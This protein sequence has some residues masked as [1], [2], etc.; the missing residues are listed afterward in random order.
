MSIRGNR[1]FYVNS[2]KRVSG[3]PSNFQYKLDIPT[4]ERF[5]TCCVL[6]LTIPKSFY[7]VRAGQNDFTVVMDGI[8]TV[9]TVPPGNYTSLN[10]IPMLTGLLNGLGQG[11]FTMSL[12]TIS[13]KYTYTYTGP[14][15]DVQFRL[16]APSMLGHQLGFPE[17]SNSTFV[18]GTLTSANVLDFIGTSTAF[19]HSDMVEDTSSILQEVY[20]DNK[21]PFSNMIYNCQFPA[22]YSKKMTNRSSTVFNFSLCD[23]HGMEI[24]LNG[25]ELLFTLL[26]YKKEDLTKLFKTIFVDP[27]E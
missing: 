17:V 2:E 22:M 23:E 7:L 4:Q 10:F 19:L 6:A 14:A 9:L 16:S 1:I 11:T 8:E 12:S 3:T 15:T 21:V 20:S 5:D 24:D 18:A 27:K 13:G 26:L 25:H